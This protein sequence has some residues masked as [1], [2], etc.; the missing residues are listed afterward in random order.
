MD[1]AQLLTIE[2][3]ETSEPVPEIPFYDISWN[4]PVDNP[5]YVLGLVYW[6]SNKYGKPYFQVIAGII[7]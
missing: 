7:Y 4:S 5:S 6:Q 2:K 3:A 1:K